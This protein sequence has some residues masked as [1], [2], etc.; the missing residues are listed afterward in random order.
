VHCNLFRAIWVG[1]SEFT[2]MGPTPTM[3]KERRF[4][5]PDLPVAS[6]SPPRRSAT[7]STHLEA[8]SPTAVPPPQTGML[9]PSD[10]GAG[11]RRRARTHR[12][13]WPARGRC[14][15]LSRAC[16]PGGGCRTR[17]RACGAT[18]A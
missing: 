2:G 17:G 13:S 10:D 6:A 15:A 3:C 18:A 8:A 5:Y 11:M 4:T 16:R 12:P 7:A 9:L 14:R 1:E